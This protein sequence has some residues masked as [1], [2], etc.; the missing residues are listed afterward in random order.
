M[1]P[2]QALPKVLKHASPGGFTPPG[3]RTP[4]G[5]GSGSGYGKLSV[6]GGGALAGIRFNDADTASQASGSSAISALEE[7]EKSLR[8]RLIVLEEQRFFV[9]EMIA[10]ANKRRKFDEVSALAQN[11]QDLSTE[12]DQIQG[13]IAQLDFA[14]A[15]AGSLGIDTPPASRG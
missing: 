6:N 2:L 3:A 13:Q 7:E 11:V 5:H 4:N 9:S 14:G 8:D 10:D 1:L 12:I 15:Y